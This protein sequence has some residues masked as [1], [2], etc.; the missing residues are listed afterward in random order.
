MAVWQ[1]VNHQEK[2]LY[3]SFFTFLVRDIRIMHVA[4]AGREKKLNHFWSIQE[5]FICDAHV[6]QHLYGGAAVLEY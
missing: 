1:Y 4:L 6:I 2:M 5:R 3:Y